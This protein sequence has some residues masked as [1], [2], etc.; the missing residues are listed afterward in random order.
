MGKKVGKIKRRP[1]HLY[2]VDKS[3]N[4]MEAPLKHGRKRKSTKRRK[5]R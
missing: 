4:V 1:G 3:G 5:R 2:Y